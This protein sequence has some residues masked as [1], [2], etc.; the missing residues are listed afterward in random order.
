ML[1]QNS[2]TVLSGNIGQC[3]I[4]A[5]KGTFFEKKKKKKSTKSYIPAN[6]NPFPSV[7]HQSK[8]LHNFQKRGQLLIVRC[9]TTEHWKNQC[10]STIRK[11]A[12]LWSKYKCNILLFLLKIY[13]L[14]HFLPLVSFYTPWNP[15]EN[16]R[17]PDVFRRFRKRLEVW[18]GLRLSVN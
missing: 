6:P 11:H 14:T 1:I 17:F 16:Q 18:N 10:R 15:S 8:A 3:P 13:L 2:L 12:L 9:I 7:F 5:R 4:L